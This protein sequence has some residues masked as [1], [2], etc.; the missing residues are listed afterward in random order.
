MKSDFGWIPSEE[1]RIGRL[2]N[3]A[4]DF[5]PQS[6]QAVSPGNMALPALKGKCSVAD[7]TQGQR[8]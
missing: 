6:L 3:P 8:Q 7:L 5:L 1:G 2:R 4:A